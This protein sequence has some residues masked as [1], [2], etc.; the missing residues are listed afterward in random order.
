MKAYTYQFARVFIFAFLSHLEMFV[1]R[2]RKR[3]MASSIFMEID[4]KKE[5]KPTVYLAYR[6][7]Q[8]VLHS[9]YSKDMS[10]LLSLPFTLRQS[11]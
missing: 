10:M 2:H 5:K 8:L 3:G 1:D 6:Y 11:T 4:I 9:K 7:L